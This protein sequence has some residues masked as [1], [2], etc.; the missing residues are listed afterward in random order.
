M[1]LRRVTP[2]ILTYNEEAN[3]ERTLDRL[4]WADRIVVVDS[5]SDDATVDIATSNDNVDLIQHEFDDHVRQ[6]N[7]GLDRVETPWVLS[8]DA[9]YLVPAAFVEEMGSLAPGPNLAGYR[10]AF[11][12]CV[13]GR[14]LRQS[15]YPPRI[16]LF[17]KEKARYVPDGHTQ[18]L[19]P[20]GPVATLDTPLKHDDR[21]SLDRW[22]DSQRRYGP[23]EAE[24]LTDADELNLA[25]RIRRTNVLAPILVPLY[26]LF[27]KGLIL[28]GWAGWYY[29]LQRTY[30]EVLRALVRVDAQLREEAEGGHE[31]KGR[32]SD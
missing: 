22:L 2:L 4:T 3:I 7:F 32:R 15:L 6:W 9:D 5:C 16:V 13:H 21:K 18:R 23:L 17:R 12:Y 31:D 14:P 11:T 1:E 28:D 10:A 25:D 26:C 24:K 30:A 8:L 20:D 27:V 29:T 19:S